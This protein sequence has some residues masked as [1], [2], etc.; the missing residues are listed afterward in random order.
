MDNLRTML[1]IGYRT[2]FAL[3]SNVLLAQLSKEW[4]THFNNETSSTPTSNTV[5]LSKSTF[6]FQFPQN[7]KTELNQMAVTSLTNNN[8]TP[9]AL[10]DMLNRDHEFVCSIAIYFEDSHLLVE[11][12]NSFI[13]LSP[14]MCCVCK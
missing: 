13:L 5:R 7:N 12:D 2:L 10:I 9:S 6:T 8:A 3:Y 4:L 1:C 14:E 11:D